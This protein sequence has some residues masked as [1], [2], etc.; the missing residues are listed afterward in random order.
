[1]EELV[2]TLI[3]QVKLQT[4]TI[5]TLNENDKMLYERLVELERKIENFKQPT[6]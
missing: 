3:E 5:K 1:M 6:I 2:N 4:Q